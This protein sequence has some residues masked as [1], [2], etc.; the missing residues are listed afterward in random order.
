MNK[1]NADTKS[2]GSTGLRNETRVAERLFLVLTI[3]LA[4]GTRCGAGQTSGGTITGT[5]YDSAGAVVNGAQVEIVNTATNATQNLT[6]EGAGLFNA[7]NLNPGN[8]MVTVTA[9][10]FA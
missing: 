7:P 2:I 5:V 10:G 9:S 3:I 6:T 4:I 8:Y 1:N